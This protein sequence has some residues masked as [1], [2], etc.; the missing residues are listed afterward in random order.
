M[1]ESMVKECVRTP[2]K[3]LRVKGSA[4]SKARGRLAKWIHQ[5]DGHHLLRPLCGLE[6][7]R[8]LGF[9]DGASALPGESSDSF[10]LAHCQVTG[11]SFPV[12][13]VANVLKSWAAWTR[14]SDALRLKPGFPKVFSR[15]EALA[16]LQPGGPPRQA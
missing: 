5:E 9:P 7:D 4:S 6:R 12:P 13:L 16:A 8:C 3:D 14:S 10:N 11:N 2:A 1:L 15:A